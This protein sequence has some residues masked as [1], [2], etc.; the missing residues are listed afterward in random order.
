MAAHVTGGGD[1]LDFVHPLIPVSRAGTPSDPSVRHWDRLFDS[2]PIKGD[3]CKTYRHSRVG[4]NLWENPTW[5]I[6]NLSKLSLF[7]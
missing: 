4:G 1:W 2:S 5:Q 6:E 3:L 7:D